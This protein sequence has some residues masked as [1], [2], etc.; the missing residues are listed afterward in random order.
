[1]TAVPN[2]VSPELLEFT[3]GKITSP[4]AIPSFQPPEYEDVEGD[5]ETGP[6][7]TLTH[8]QAI[9][10]EYGKLEHV[11]FQPNTQTIKGNQGYGRLK[12]EAKST[13]GLSQP[14]INQRSLNPGPV[15][16]DYED[17][18]DGPSE[19]YGKLERPTLARHT[20]YPSVVGPIAGYGQLQKSLQT[21][22]RK[23]APPKP[24]PY[25]PKS[26]E[27]AATLL[28]QEVYSEIDAGAKINLPAQSSR[29]GY[30]K[31]ARNETSSSSVKARST[32]PVPEGYGVLNRR[33][34][35]SNPEIS[36]NLE[37]YGTLEHFPR[38]KS[39]SAFPQCQPQG[40]GKLEHTT[41][42]FNPYG[43]LSRNYRD[44]Q[45]SQRAW[46]KNSA[47]GEAQHGKV[48]DDDITP[49]YSVVD[50]KA[51][52]KLPKKPFKPLQSGDSLPDSEEFYDAISP[53]EAYDDVLPQPPK[54]KTELLYESLDSKPP[55]PVPPR[56][57]ASTRSTSHVHPP[58]LKATEQQQE[59]RKPVIL[60]K[61][62]VKPRV[63]PKP[64]LK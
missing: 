1:M 20:S 23:V 2:H 29:Q 44:E 41:P 7:V 63:K 14:L 35:T 12:R 43:S 22:K 17:V 56:R 49:E 5:F 58:E 45:Q 51:L 9:P 46:T 61:P 18:P 53:I 4:T 26:A 64:A 27:P 25:R 55:P 39:P 38:S 54:P 50:R 62:S 32:S 36:T 59:E 37:R 31:L 57:G 33:N 11:S 6:G 47:N 30:N 10:E 60:P 8:R 13:P 42:L 3:D 48:S 40:Y 34:S 24:P 19:G 52:R 21:K 15:R 16:S 28:V